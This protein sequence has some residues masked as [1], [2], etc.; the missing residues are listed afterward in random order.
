MSGACV[1]VMQSCCVHRM[2]AIQ[3][4]DNRARLVAQKRP[5]SVLD[6]GS[7]FDDTQMIQCDDEHTV[8]SDYAVSET[9]RQRLNTKFDEV[10]LKVKKV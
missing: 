7:L 5:Y 10:R 4:R 6:D 3:E 9:K 8:P 2:T 1:I